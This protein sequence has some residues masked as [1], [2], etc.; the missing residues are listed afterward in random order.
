MSIERLHVVSWRDLDD[1]EAGGSE[2]HIN[3]LA[4]RWAASGLDVVI[5]TGAVRG[6]EADIARDGYRVVRRGG[7]VTGLVRSPLSEVLRRQGRRDALVEVWHGINF[8]APLWCRGPRVAIAHHVHGE[9]FRYVL[10]A[11]AAAAAALM[12]RRISPLLYRSTPL[13]TLSPSTREEL[14]GLGHPPSNVHVVT[15]GVDPRFS[16]GGL[17]APRPVVLTVGRLMPQ[18]RVDEVFE[19]LRP[20][21]ARFPDLEHVVVGAGPD[22]PRLRRLAPPWVRFAGRVP[23][24]ELVD[25][26]RSAWVVAS[27]SVAEGWNMTLTEAGACATPAVASRIAGH[28]DAVV[29][30]ETGFLADDRASFTEKLGLV[31]SDD[32]LRARLGETAARRS[33]RHTWDAA[34]SAV[35]DVLR[36]GAPGV[37]GRDRC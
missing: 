3:Q 37:A 1:P 32:A 26:Y 6:A 28:V 12:E 22:E 34:A 27:A 4:R 33:R 8:L 18:K 30:G 21:R 29:E 9:Q 5:R 13:V 24:G 7:R 2:L 23:D 36:T 15:P 11:P 10:P 17:R 25:L 16:P 20:L 31:L 35:L 14:V 19:A